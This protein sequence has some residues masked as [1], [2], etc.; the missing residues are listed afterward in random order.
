MSDP[1]ICPLAGYCERHG[2]RKSKHWHGLCQRS[3][4]YRAAWDAGTGP[5]QDR[6][7]SADD[8]AR[9][10][11]REARR[12]RIIIATA[13][14]TRL[15]SWLNFFSIPADRGVGDTAHRLAMRACKHPDANAE[16]LRL[17]KKCSCRRPDAITQLNEKYP[18]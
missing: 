17:L 13:K 8:P 2:V 12:D 10:A 1:C 18:Y 6:T 15:I 7:L 4:T 5:G 3:E 11:E 9:L 14:E 16:I